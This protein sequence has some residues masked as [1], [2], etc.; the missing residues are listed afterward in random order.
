MWSW[1]VVAAA[2]IALAA[3]SVVVAP[4]VID[5]FNVTQL[6]KSRRGNV[7]V[8]QNVLLGLS[9]VIGVGVAILIRSLN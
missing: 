3:V 1:V 2:V 9:I 7:Y 4:R 8:L 6:A 5:K